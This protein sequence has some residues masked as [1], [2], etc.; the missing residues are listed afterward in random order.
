MRIS[1][2]L[3]EEE[4]RLL[5][6]AASRMGILP[7]GLIRAVL[8]DFLGGAESEDE[9]QRVGEWIFKQNKDLYRKPN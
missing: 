8:S 7:E 9:T 3:S 1:V 2:N 5:G 4:A 6:A